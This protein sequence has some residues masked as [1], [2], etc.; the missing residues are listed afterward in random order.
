MPSPSMEKEMK[1]KLRLTSSRSLLPDKNR[2]MAGKISQGKA[3]PSISGCRRL[4]GLFIQKTSHPGLFPKPGKHNVSSMELSNKIMLITYADSLG[5]DLKELE[6]ALE[7]YF[8]GAVGGLHILPFFPSSADRGFSPLTYDIVDPAFGDWEDIARL[9]GKYYLMFDYMINH[10]SSE[11]EAFKDFVD[12]KD[13]SEFREFFIRYKDFWSK[14][15]PTQRDLD[16]MYKRKAVPWIEVRFKDGSEEKL[17]TTFSDYQ[18]DINQKS[19]RAQ[20][21]HRENIRKLSGHGAALIRLDAIAYAAKREGTSCFFSEPEIWDLFSQC[22]GYFEGTGSTMLPEIHE[23]YF[24]LQKVEEHGYYVYDFQLPMLL[25]NA[26]YYGRSAYLK[27]WLRICPH[28][29]FTTLDTHD[30]IGVVD[31]RYLMPDEELLRTR[32]HCFDLNPGVLETYPRAGLKLD[33]DRFDTHQINCT[34]YSA[35]GEDDDKY[36]LTRAVQFFTPGIPQVHYVGA[37][38]GRNDWEGYWKTLHAR[39]LNRHNYTLEELEEETK[40]PIVRRLLSLMAFRNSHPAFNGEFE[41]LPSSSSTLHMSWRNGEEYA[42]LYADF[43]SFSA[44]IRYSEN[45]V[46][47]VFS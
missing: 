46:E 28:R 47:R 45:G 34:Y 44:E 33:L 16:V 14:G 8:K 38:C 25:L 9:S 17:W 41:L 6:T 3:I 40:R 18:I 13:E 20:A 37:L 1:T 36:F 30:G 39:D 26:I 31:A 22:G 35:L 4:S 24:L 42:R 32:R 11:S 29:Q 15:E 2:S 10:I 19:A 23:N 5:K 27:N 21:F 12:K 43:L 7:R